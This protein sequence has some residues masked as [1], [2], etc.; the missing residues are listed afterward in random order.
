MS[1]QNIYHTNTVKNCCIIYRV[2]KIVIW[3]HSNNKL[4]IVDLVFMHNVRG[5]RKIMRYDRLTGKILT[6]LLII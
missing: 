1:F 6:H 5:G 2:N 3:K 4:S